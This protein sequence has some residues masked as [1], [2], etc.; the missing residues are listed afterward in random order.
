MNPAPAD[1][2]R[3]DLEDAHP[4]RRAMP[5]GAD[6][7]I[8][9][10]VRT[11]TALARALRNRQSS[12]TPTSSQLSVLRILVD[13]GPMSPT[14]S[15]DTEQVRPS[16]ISRTLAILSNAR[17]IERHPHPNDRRSAIIT[18]TES[19]RASIEAAS[20]T[21]LRWLVER[22][23]L[24]DHRQVTVLRAAVDVLAALDRTAAPPPSSDPSDRPIRLQASDPDTATMPARGV[25]TRSR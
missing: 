4:A 25:T 1:A 20:T 23:A 11:S 24:L 15:A 17:L 3:P 16:W 10:L 7:H 18:A 12:A 8:E 13:N 14:A 2:D 21:Q 19:G 5:P 9:Q 6:D 22:L